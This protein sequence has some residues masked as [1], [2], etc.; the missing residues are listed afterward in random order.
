MYS[1]SSRGAG[2]SQL[3]R[4]QSTYT[5]LTGLPTYTPLPGLP[6]YTP[7]EIP[8]SIPESNPALTPSS[9]F[10][11]RQL[12]TDDAFADMRA[13]F[14]SN[15]LTNLKFYNA[16]N[17]AT[18]LIQ[19][20]EELAKSGKP[21]N[22]IYDDLYRLVHEELFPS[23]EYII[24]TQNSTFSRGQ[25]RSEKLRAILRNFLYNHTINSYLDVGCGEGS[26]TSDVGKMMKSGRILGCD[27][28]VPPTTEG[29][30]FTLLDINDPNRLPYESNSQ[31]VV[32]TFMSLHHIKQ[33]ERTLA[34]IYRV[35]RDDG[36]YVIREHDCQP[37][38]LSLLLDLMHGFYAMVWPLQREMADFAT[39]FAKYRTSDE[40]TAIIERSGFVSVHQSQP[41]G[42]WRHYY[43][44][45]V[46][47]STFERQRSQIQ[48]WFPP[49][50]TGSSGSRS[51]GR[52]R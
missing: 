41:V 9:R 50:H 20:T 19:R 44:V 37:A 6:T 34:E 39:H 51:S 16:P 10:Q 47:R 36:I 3:R 4:P 2:S 42:A 22:V 31:D 32:S 43:Q 45:F 33:P 24:A 38:K 25:D 17:C 40:L 30:E 28:Y 46:K 15:I 5:P 49:S 27:V 48:S 12:F 8:R 23:N 13:L 11:L 14:I 21:D 1:S 18:R 52:Q 35:L 26:I 29:F 7:R